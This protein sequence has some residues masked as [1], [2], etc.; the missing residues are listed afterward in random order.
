MILLRF[1]LFLFIIALGMTT[2][3]G[4]DQA[5]EVVM[6]LE[7]SVKT[8]SYDSGYQFLSGPWL[9]MIAPVPFENT[10]GADSIDVDSLADASDG[11]VTE[12]RIA[13]NGARI[14]DSVGEFT[15]TLHE[16]RPDTVSKHENFSDNVNEVVSGI[17]WYTGNADS[18]SAYA[19][20]V[21]ESPAAQNNV[22]MR[23]SSDDAIKVWLNG[24]VVHTNTVNRGVTLPVSTAADYQDW[25]TVNLQSGD[26]LLMVKVSEQFRAWAMFVM[27]EAEVNAR[28]LGE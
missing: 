8:V 25:F 9:W 11:L 19:L 12:T 23:V 16:I 22:G 14:G 24:E 2:L 15:W 3:F 20:L 7:T 5:R 4:C 13:R 18:H 21:L 17:G 1:N 27:I 10:G 6:P 28:I 26:N